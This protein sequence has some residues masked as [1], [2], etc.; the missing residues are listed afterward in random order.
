MHLGRRSSLAIIYSVGSFILTGKGG[1]RQNAP[2]LRPSFELPVRPLSI[3]LVWRKNRHYWQLP[4]TAFGFS[5]FK[6]V[7][8]IFAR[9]TSCF[10]F[11][12]LVSDPGA[13][14]A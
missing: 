14:V 6:A 3:N 12:L 5:L 2:D 7:K 4:E 11:I 13:S 10:D 9:H 1:E 8:I